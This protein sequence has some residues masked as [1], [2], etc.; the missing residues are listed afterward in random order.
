MVELSNPIPIGDILYQKGHWEY[1]G[2]Q[3]VSSYLRVMEEDG[4]VTRIV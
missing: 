1:L 2:W 4:E 3:Y